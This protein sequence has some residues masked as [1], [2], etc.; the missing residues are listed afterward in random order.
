MLE[1]CISAPGFQNR[2]KS[3]IC[4]RTLLS[5]EEFLQMLILAISMNPVCVLAV[6]S[7]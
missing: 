5:T 7:V 6:K 2:V 3:G 1:L 4:K